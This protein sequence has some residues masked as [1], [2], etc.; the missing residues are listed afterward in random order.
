MSYPY[1]QDRTRDKRTKGEQPYEAARE[2]FSKSE[3]DLETEAIAY[4]D[5]H[6]EA[7][8]EERRARLEAEMEQRFA[9]INREVVER[10]DAEADRRKTSEEG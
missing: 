3:H 6:Q 9:K 8:S 2:T 10:A 4:G 5:A 7:D 1:P